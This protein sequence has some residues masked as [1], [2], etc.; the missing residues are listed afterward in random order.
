MSLPSA[1]H[2]TPSVLVFK[3]FLTALSNQSVLVTRLS[4]RRPVIASAM[5]LPFGNVIVHAAVSFAS[6]TYVV[7]TVSF[8]S[9]FTVTFQMPDMLASDTGAAGA[10]VA[11]IA[12]AEVATAAVSAAGALSFG[13]Q[14]TA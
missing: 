4:P 7:T 5:G 2:A 8:P 13:V 3:P 9:G 6:R 12:D 14:P 11:G 10:A 1:I